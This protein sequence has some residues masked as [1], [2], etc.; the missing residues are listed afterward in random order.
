MS[1]GGLLQQI[2]KGVQLNS[3]DDVDD[4]SA[5]KLEGM[6]VTILC[7]GIIVTN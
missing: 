7:V 5:P 4:R 1:R 3:A 2:K 6:H